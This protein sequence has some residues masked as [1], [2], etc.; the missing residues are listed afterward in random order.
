MMIATIYKITVDL[1]VD[2][3][4]GHEESADSDGDLGDRFAKA[5]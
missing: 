3:M 2:K 4:V 1:S 5:R